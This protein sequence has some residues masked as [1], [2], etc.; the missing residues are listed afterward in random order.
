MQRSDAERVGSEDRADGADP[1]FPQTA[2]DLRSGQIVLRRH[3][4][5]EFGPAAHSDDFVQGRGGGGIRSR[6]RGTGR[7]SPRGTMVEA[8]RSQST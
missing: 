1:H 2:G 3:D 5:F 4:R 7:S 6:A 8:E